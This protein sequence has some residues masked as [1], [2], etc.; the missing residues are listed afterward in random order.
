MSHMTSAASLGT[1]TSFTQACAQV[2]A[3]EIVPGAN[4]TPNLW[5]TVRDAYRQISMLPEPEPGDADSYRAGLR[6]YMYVP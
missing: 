5:D 1:R 4:A 6:K 3:A 2:P